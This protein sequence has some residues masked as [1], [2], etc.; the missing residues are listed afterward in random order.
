MLPR[1][2]SSEGGF[3]MK[4][5]PIAKKPF[6]TDKDL[7]EALLLISETAK[8]LALEVMLLPEDVNKGDEK[9]VK[10]SNGT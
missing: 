1:H 3:E 6:L 2:I 10:K 7:A 4:K 9:D 8:T 5:E